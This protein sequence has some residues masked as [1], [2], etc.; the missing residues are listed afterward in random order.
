MN[1]MFMN[2]VQFYENITIKVIE[3]SV[4]FL[5]S[6]FFEEV[7]YKQTKSRVK[8]EKNFKNIQTI[9][10]NGKTFYQQH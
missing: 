6:S 1:S 2:L 5:S 3:G 10:I 7:N 8:K 4:E 9:A